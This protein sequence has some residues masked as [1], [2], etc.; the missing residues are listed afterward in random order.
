MAR[1]LPVKG[2]LKMAKSKLK[3][4]KI[5]D[6]KSYC[7]YFSEASFADKLRAVGGLLG[8]NILLPV[9]KAYYVLRS[10]TTKAS[11]KAMLM[12]ALGYFILPVDFLPDFLAGLIGFGDD[13]MVISFVLGKI[14]N[15]ITPEIEEK[16]EAAYAKIVGPKIA[17]L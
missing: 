10:P 16:A 13:L 7:K 6:L 17:A 11:E 4:I 15:N 8:K 9:L 1:K 5:E 14:H 3:E 12:G 2:L